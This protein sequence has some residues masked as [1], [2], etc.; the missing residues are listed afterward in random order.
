MVIID[1]LLSKLAPHTCLS[2]GQEGDLVCISCGLAVFLSPSNEPIESLESTA[3][4]SAYNGVARD[5]VWQ[6]KFRGAR[7][8]AGTMA[9]Y[10]A[11]LT[12]AYPR[13]TVIVPIPTATRRVRRRGFD[14]ARLLA[15]HVS[16][17]TG[18]QYLD[19]LQRNGQTHQVGASREQRLR[20]LEAA[21]MLKKPVELRGRH[22]VLID[23]VLTTGATLESAALAARKTR[24]AG[25]SAVVFA[26]AD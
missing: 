15:R 16:K 23:D 1:T 6:L 3:A 14:Q 19:L 10:M 9:R 17:R 7:A 26:R 22:I 18:L 24:P 4:V 13:N 11:P 5:L 20:Q 8:A 2:C 21:F 25:V 12:Q